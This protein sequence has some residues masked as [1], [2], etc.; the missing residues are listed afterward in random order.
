MEN[1]YL[2]NSPIAY[3]IDDNANKEWLVFCWG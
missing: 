1:L 3:Y 2:D